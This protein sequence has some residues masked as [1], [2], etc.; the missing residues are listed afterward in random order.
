MMGS[1]DQD[2]VPVIES[3]EH[4]PQQPQLPDVHDIP[5]GL[6]KQLLGQHVPRLAGRRPQIPHF[7]RHRSRGVHLLE[8][9][10]GVPHHDGA[11]D[12]MPLHHVVQGALQCFQVYL[13]G[14]A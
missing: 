10:L 6:D 9:R 13:P 2:P 14:D 11:E 5:L 3:S 7:Q 8:R 1:Q 4:G 12:L